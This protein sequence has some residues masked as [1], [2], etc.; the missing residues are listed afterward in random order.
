[1]MK[2]YGVES[3]RNRNQSI[4]LLEGLDFDFMNVHKLDGFNSSGLLDI[5]SDFLFGT[6]IHRIYMLSQRIFLMILYF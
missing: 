2:F 1:M 5:D 4:D 6:G 3:Y